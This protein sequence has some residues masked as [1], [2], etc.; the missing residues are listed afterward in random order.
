MQCLPHFEK[1]KKKKDLLTIPSD[2]HS[3]L[4][5]RNSLTFVVFKQVINETREQ[6][7]ESK[8]GIHKRKHSD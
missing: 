6:S 5:L 2:N 1:K 4:K 3:V 7:D 8:F